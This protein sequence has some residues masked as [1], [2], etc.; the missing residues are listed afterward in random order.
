M[1]KDLKLF[2]YVFVLWLTLEITMYR[3]SFLFG[4]GFGTKPDRVRLELEG[5]RLMPATFG[6]DQNP[7]GIFSGA[8][9]PLLYKPLWLRCL[10]SI[11][12]VV[13]QPSCTWYQ[14]LC[15]RSVLNLWSCTTFLPGIKLLETKFCCHVVLP[16][17][18]SVIDAV[19]QVC[20]GKNPHTNWWQ[21]WDIANLQLG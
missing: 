10:V 12:P 21:R 15:C 4:T 17:P 19:S 1:C 14:L 20:I 9:A 7:F 16:Y 18:S 6:S 3:M 11:R 8:S 2:N 5:V 13:V